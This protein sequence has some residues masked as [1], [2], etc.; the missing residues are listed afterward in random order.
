MGVLLITSVG[1][2]LI[3]SVGV[4]LSTSV[5]VLLIPFVGDVLIT[6]VGDI[7]ITSV[8]DPKRLKA[9]K[10]DFIATG[11]PIM[12]SLIQQHGTP[13]AKRGAQST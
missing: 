5:G 7:L 9:Q 4:L 10:I 13:P 3:T 6:F 11:L 8:G 12:L 2:L 1:V